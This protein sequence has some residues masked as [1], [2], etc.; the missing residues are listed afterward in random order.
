MTLQLFDSHAHL[1]V[2]GVIEQVD[3]ILERA[4]QAK[5]KTI[6]NICIDQ[7]SYEKGL[8]IQGRYPWVLNAGATTP[9]DV[10][11]F[12]E[13]DFPVF[14]QAAKEGKL[15]AIGE[16]GL[17]YYYEHSKKKTQKTYL[18]RYL[19]LAQEVDLPVIFHCRDA[20]EDLFSI[21]DQEY[22]GKTAILHCFTGSLKEAE[23]VLKRGWYL[24]LSGIVTFK[25]SEELREVAKM[26]PLHQLLIETDTPYLAP[27]S[28][29]GKPNEP[30][31]LME[32]AQL[33]ADQ[34]K[35]DVAELV[36]Q[37]YENAK[38]CLIPFNF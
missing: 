28:K 7:T 23:Q 34:K 37:T 20:F 9:H 31:Y 2:P 16:T 10:D 13:K 15:V 5:I 19:H 29:R 8:E 6:L 27:Q 11:K 3:S 25:K 30:S 18:V 36:R 32:T 22:R 24:S 35:M 12:G 1:S 26:I 4:H 33:I 38:R 14:E 17:D 21:A